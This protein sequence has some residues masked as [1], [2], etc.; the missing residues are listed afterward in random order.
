[1][2]LYNIGK[3]NETFLSSA[4]QYDYEENEIPQIQHGDTIVVVGGG[5]IGLSTTYDLAKWVSDSSLQAKII[6]IESFDNPFAATSATC[7]GCFHYGF[8]ENETQP[9]LP[10]GKYSFDMWAA[11]AENEEFRKATGYRAYSSFG[12]NQGSG[13]GIVALPNWMHIEPTWDVD[14]HILGIHNATVFVF[15]DLLMLELDI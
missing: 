7:T 15:P 6:V 4:T 11:Q 12:I 1:M 3:D 14:E 10:L 8:P 9:L 2:Q 5:S 13:R